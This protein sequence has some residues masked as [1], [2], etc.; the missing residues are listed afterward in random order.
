MV[1]RALELGRLAALD[2]VDQKLEDA[3]DRAALR[4]RVAFARLL[5]RP[6]QLHGEGVLFRVLGE[7]RQVPAHRVTK[8]GIEFAPGTAAQPISQLPSLVAVV[9]SNRVERWRWH[10][11][12]GG[13]HLTR[14]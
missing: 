4:A 10:A 12:E 14:D 7:Q 11:V 2:V 6:E 8:L 5:N 3:R 1:E 9:R 13:D